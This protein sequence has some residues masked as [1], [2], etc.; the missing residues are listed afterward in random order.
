MFCGTMAAPAK[1]AF[2]FRGVRPPQQMSTDE[3]Q[4]VERV[5]TDAL[6]EMHGE[7]EGEYYPMPKSHSYPARLGGMSKQ[8]AQLLETEGL[9]FKSKECIGRGV[10]ATLEK[11]IAIFVNAESHLEVIVKPELG[12]HDVAPRRLNTLVKFLGD[13]FKLSGYHLA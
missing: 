2:N 11:D 5:I 3:L 12:D 1:K 13:H 10:F 7:F 9:L 4:D 6:L 8:E